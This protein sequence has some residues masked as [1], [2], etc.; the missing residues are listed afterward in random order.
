MGYIGVITH[1]LTIYQLPGTSKYS[2]VQPPQK[3]QENHLNQIFQGIMFYVKYWFI[4]DPLLTYL[5]RYRGHLFWPKGNFSWWSCKMGT[6][7]PG[8]KRIRLSVLRIRDYV[9]LQSYDL[10]DGMSLDHQSY[11]FSGPMT[12]R[13]SGFFKPEAIGSTTSP[14]N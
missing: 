8:V 11:E 3:R 2:Q 4:R 10:G 6:K 14:W 7:S 5:K 9:Y 13:F 1:L 12:R